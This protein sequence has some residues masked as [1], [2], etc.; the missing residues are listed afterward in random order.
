MSLSVPS[1]TTSAHDFMAMCVRPPGTQHCAS[2]S[3]KAEP[4]RSERKLTP[5]A[6]RDKRAQH[7]IGEL[8]IFH[9]L[10]RLLSAD[11]GSVSNEP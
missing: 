5:W 4:D 1:F 3:G 10:G 2:L 9:F 11:S 6:F 7:L 8:E